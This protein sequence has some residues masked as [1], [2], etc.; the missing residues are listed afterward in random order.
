MAKAIQLR[1]TPSIMK[2]FDSME[3][4]NWAWIYDRQIQHKSA[5]ESLAESRSILEGFL[6][7]LERSRSSAQYMLCFYEDIKDR[8]KIRIST[9]ADF[10]YNVCLFDPEEYPE[11]G[12]VTRRE[13]YQQLADSLAQTNAQIALLI[14]QREEEQEED[15]ESVSGRGSGLIGAIDKLL[16]NPKIQERLGEKI[17]GWVDSILSPTPPP[18]MQNKQIGAMG[19]VSGQPTGQPIKEITQEQYDKINA[20]VSILASIDPNLGDHLETI[21][22]LAQEKPKKYSSLITMLNTFL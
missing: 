6:K 15:D 13:S 16:D 14:K 20:A 4:P 11:P 9:E 12:S 17:I 7:Q 18:A 19:N 21:A 5:G 8:K 1:G 10:S 3:I 22:K 2:C